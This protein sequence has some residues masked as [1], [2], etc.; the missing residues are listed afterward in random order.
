MIGCAHK[1]PVSL[2]NIWPVR[3]ASRH[4]YQVISSAI[5]NESRTDMRQIAKRLVLGL[6][7]AAQPRIGNLGDRTTRALPCT[8]QHST[9][10]SFMADRRKTADQ[11]K[12]LAV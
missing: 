1:F 5:C 2:R 11:R 7:A 6:T 4:W 10:L 9:A 12:K 3:I 8:A